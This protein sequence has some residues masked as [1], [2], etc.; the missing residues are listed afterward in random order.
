MGNHKGDTERDLPVVGFA[1]SFVKRMGKL[2][3]RRRVR[4][5]WSGTTSTTNPE[6]NRARL[7]LR[8]DEGREMLL[9]MTP[10]EF[11]ALRQTMDDLGSWMRGNDYAGM[12]R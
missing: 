9:T 6:L 7:Y 3:K 4:V 11:Q 1:T 10:E 12:G 5:T 8:D 2:V